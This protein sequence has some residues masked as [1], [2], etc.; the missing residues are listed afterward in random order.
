[1]WQMMQRKTRNPDLV[2]STKVFRFEELQEAAL[3]ANVFQPV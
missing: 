2:A 1:M 3:L